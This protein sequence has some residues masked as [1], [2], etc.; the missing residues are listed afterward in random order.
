MSDDELLELYNRYKNCYVTVHKYGGE[1][2]H[3]FTL[4]EIVKLAQL[5][6]KVSIEGIGGYG[7]EDE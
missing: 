5:H 1:V 3:D 7:E 2:S 6:I 4:K